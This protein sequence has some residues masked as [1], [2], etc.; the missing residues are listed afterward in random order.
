MPDLGPPTP[1]LGHAVDEGEEADEV[2]AEE[3]A[4]AVSRAVGVA[5]GE[6]ADEVLAVELAVAVSRAA[7]AQ[8]CARARSGVP[9]RW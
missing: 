8:I 7:A 3:L 4:V 6:E 1:D 2:L 5:E 9:V